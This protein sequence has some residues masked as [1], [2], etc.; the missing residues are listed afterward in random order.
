MSEMTHEQA[1]ELLGPL[2]RGELDQARAR[3]LERHLA[4]CE[5]CRAEA[6]GL[7]ALLAADHE[8][9][10]D[11]ERRALRAAVAKEVRPERATVTVLPA[12]RT[13]WER[14]AGQF[15][16][17]AASLVVILFAALVWMGLGNDDAENGG[18]GDGAT[19][20][21]GGEG[22]AGA[23]PLAD[24]PK[25]VFAGIERKA[26]AAQEDAVAPQDQANYRAQLARVEYTEKTLSR[27]G[28]TGT[29][30]RRFVNAYSPEAALNLAPAFLEQL[31][32]KAPDETL[33]TQVQDCG[34][35]VL[36]FDPSR[37]VL[38]TFA[39]SA[40]FNGE[41]ALI[42]GFVAASEPG[43]PLDQYSIS[44]WPEGSC[45]IPLTGQQ[46]DIGGGP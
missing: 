17:A 2:Q 7:R 44:A 31:A 4:E 11:E 28:A 12:R 27:L 15:V 9:L 6:A 21:S 26:A 20:E 39:T 37:P 38:P 34:N 41:R 45:D 8:P 25:P 14:H 46:G 23:A 32:G 33:A 40:R 22:A 36:G 30:F 43:G 18:G 1:S 19:L 3:E 24:G 42:I 16:G 5:E 29:I 10:S 35:M 13:F